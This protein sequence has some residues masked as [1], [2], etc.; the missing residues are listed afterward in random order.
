[1]TTYALT[2]A[3][4]AQINAVV[5]PTAGVPVGGGVHV[6]IPPDWQAQIAAGKAVPGCSYVLPDAA[7]NVTIDAVLS[8][9]L[10]A[11]GELEALAITAK[12]AVAT[13]VVFADVL[14]EE[15]V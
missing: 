4:C 8:A 12:L 11:S 7:G 1:M 10:A 2:L 14:L 9:K 3:D 6:V 15:V 5:P 13:P